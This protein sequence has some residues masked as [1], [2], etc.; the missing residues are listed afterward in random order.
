MIA[1]LRE[2]K[3]LLDCGISKR[4]NSFITKGI[5]DAGHARSQRHRDH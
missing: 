3:S 2:G 4:L 5:F 1:P